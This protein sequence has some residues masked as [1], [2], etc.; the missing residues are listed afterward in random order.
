MRVYYL[1]LMISMGQS[2]RSRK[3]QEDQREFYLHESPSREGNVRIDRSV[4]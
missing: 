4:F 3:Q 1:L 2:T